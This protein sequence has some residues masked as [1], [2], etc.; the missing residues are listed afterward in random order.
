MKEE[1]A[2]DKK[3][4]QGEEY[5]HVLFEVWFCIILFLR[6]KRI[7]GYHKNYGRQQIKQ[8]AFVTHYFEFIHQ[9]G[10]KENVV[11]SDLGKKESHNGIR[12]ID[13]LNS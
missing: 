5:R 2:Q 7:N 3:G 11:E 1:V 8:V 4:D 12:K 10:K 9:L 13:M 6:G